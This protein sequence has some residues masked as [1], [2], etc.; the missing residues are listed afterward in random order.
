M[1]PPPK[2]FFDDHFPDI[3]V[4]KRQQ[5]FLKEY[6]RRR[7]VKPTLPQNKPRLPGGGGKGSSSD[8]AGTGGI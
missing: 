6:H 2:G 5:Q 7:F 1:P 8:A 3:E 4:I